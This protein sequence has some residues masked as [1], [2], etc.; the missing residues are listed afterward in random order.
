MSIKD[1]DWFQVPGG[2]ILVEKVFNSAMVCVEYGPSRIEQVVK[3]LDD[4]RQWL[5]IGRRD[6]KK[7]VTHWCNPTPLPGYTAGADKLVSSI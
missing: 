7:E 4:T 6:W 5:L 3:T 1:G 2:L